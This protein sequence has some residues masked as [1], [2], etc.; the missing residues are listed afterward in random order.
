MENM[1]VPYAA[2][3]KTSIAPLA[4]AAICLSLGA[5]ILLAGCPAK[6]QARPPTR[7][8]GTVN[9]PKTFVATASVAIFDAHSATALDSPACRVLSPRPPLSSAIAPG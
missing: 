9:L 4:V 1:D 8:T 7:P 5:A 3:Q 6:P 2:P